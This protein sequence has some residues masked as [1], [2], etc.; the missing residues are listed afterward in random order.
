MLPSQDCKYNLLYFTDLEK[1]AA[2][3]K[4]IQGK[5]TLTEIVT[6]YDADYDY[7]TNQGTKAV[8]HTNKNAENYRLITIDLEKPAEANWVDL[9]KVSFTQFYRKLLL[10]ILVSKNET[11]DH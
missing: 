1:E 10:K 8:F 4:G 2:G 5:F 9:V 11:I 7:V 6:E 3:E